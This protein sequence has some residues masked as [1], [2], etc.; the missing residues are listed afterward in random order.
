VR[1]IVEFI[2]TPHGPLV[3]GNIQQPRRWIDLIL[4]ASVAIHF[5]VGASAPD[6]FNV[7]A[8]AIVRKLSKLV[9]DRDSPD[10]EHLPNLWQVTWFVAPSSN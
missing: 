6:Q 4:I 2:S 7:S 5:S 9:A 3:I 1:D 8:R 10:L